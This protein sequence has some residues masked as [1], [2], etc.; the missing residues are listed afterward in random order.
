MAGRPGR[1]AARCPVQ[2][3]PQSVTWTVSPNYGI[4]QLWE[5]PLF[6]AAGV[7]TGVLAERGRKQ[8]A[9]LERTTNRLTEVYQELQDNFES[10][11]RAERLFALGQLSAGLAHEIRNPLASIAGAAGILQR[12]PASKRK[13]PNAWRSSPRNAGG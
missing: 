7:L 1:G 9:E 13:M 10:M 8:R 6:C 11:K 5:I 4:D 12:N 2:R 3:P